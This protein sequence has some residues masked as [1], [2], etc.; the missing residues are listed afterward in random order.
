MSNF[1]KMRLTLFLAHLL[2]W[3]LAVHGQE[4]DSLPPAPTV[5]AVSF[6]Q[7]TEPVLPI[8]FHP[9]NWKNLIIQILIVH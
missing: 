9:R 2:L 4:M 3:G 8:T 5:L 7:K 1:N 6:R